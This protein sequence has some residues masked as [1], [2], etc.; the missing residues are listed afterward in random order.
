MLGY[1][2]ARAGVKAVVLEKH[3]DFLRD[4]RGDT[5][6]PSTLEVMHDLGLL[7]A[8]L[9]R[10]HDRA[11]ELSAQIGDCV[12][13][14]AD[15]TRLPTHARFI[16]FMPQWE[17]LDFL[18]GEARRFEAFKLI[19]RAEAR[20][21]VMDDARVIGVSASTPEGPLEILAPLPVGADGRH[22]TI[23][24]RAGLEVEDLGA[25]M[26]V[27]WMRLPRRPDDPNLPLG[28]ADAGRIF[29]M[30]ARGDY[31]QC[32]Y[33]VAKGAFAAI[34]SR[35]LDALRDS[36]ARM[37]PLLADRVAALASWDEVKLLTVTVDRLKRWSRPGLI[38]IGDAAHAMSPVG[39]VGINLAIQDAVAA[40]NILAAPL[41]EKRLTFA[42][43]KAVQRR[44]DLPTRLTQ[45][46]QIFIQRRVIG[47]TLGGAGPLAVPW[48]V[49]ALDRFA[50]L[51]R[52]AARVIGLGFR[53]ES[54]STPDA[55]G[56]G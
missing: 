13:R 37:V 40:A 25:P 16:A 11:D 21:L 31:F 51:R 22:S 46:L 3:G 53:R 24:E 7:E 14:V 47:P 55:R 50:P 41:A 12:V 45:S 30:I 43:L 9:E 23:C 38:C 15:F 52:L 33:V 19:M 35:G 4:F 29:V 42:D 20:D 27:L 2:L 48:P 1:L 32:G 36:I 28:R 5:V 49:K 26:D 34:R 56:G 18:S 17:F 54:V 39:G 44:R 8:F 6:H 10:P